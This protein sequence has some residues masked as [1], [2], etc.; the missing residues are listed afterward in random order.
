MMPF[1]FRLLQVLAGANWIAVHAMPVQDK[2]Q[3]LLDVV[4]VTAK[5]RVRMIGRDLSLP[6]G[7]EAFCLDIHEFTPGGWWKDVGIGI[8]TEWMPR[9]IT[10]ELVST[11]FAKI[12]APPRL[13]RIFGKPDVLKLGQASLS[14]IV[15]VEFSTMDRC[16]SYRLT[17]VASQEFPCT[18]DFAITNVGC[19][20]LLR[21]L[22]EICLDQ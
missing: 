9:N 19:N 1:D 5:E 18:I 7:D 8:S 15:A 22:T 21:G 17:C 3:A 11:G 14:A 20:E 6:N 12:L 4:L 13:C 10:E 16:N 2:R